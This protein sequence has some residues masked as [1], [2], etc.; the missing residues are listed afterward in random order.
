MFAICERLVHGSVHWP[1]DRR[2][3]G[4]SRGK[5]RKE[6]QQERTEE[7]M[8]LLNVP[9]GLLINFHE[10]KVTEGISRLILPGANL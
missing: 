6:T 7:D 10:M 8:K 3:A 9:L 4:L 1:L 2:S 5:K